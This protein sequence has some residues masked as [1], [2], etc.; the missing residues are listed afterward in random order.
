[1]DLQVPTLDSGVVAAAVDRCH[2][3]KYVLHLEVAAGCGGFI[4]ALEDFG[5]VLETGEE[6]AAVDEIKGLVVG[7][8]VLCVVDLE[9][10][11]GWDIFGLDCA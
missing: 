10:A 8:V 2:L 3:E 1:M 11:V 7:P 4:G 9:L 5:G 6:H